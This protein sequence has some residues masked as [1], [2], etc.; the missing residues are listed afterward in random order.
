MGQVDHQERRIRGSRI[1]LRAL[2]GVE[3][4]E[5]II[6]RVREEALYANEARVFLQLAV[7]IDFAVQDFADVIVWM[8]SPCGKADEYAP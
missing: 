7:W 6:L 2:S 3:H 1:L 5:G 4:P 8:V